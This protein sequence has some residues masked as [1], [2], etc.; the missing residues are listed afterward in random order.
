MIMQLLLLSKLQQLGPP[1]QY[2][3]C[4]YKK[5]PMNAQEVKDLF[6]AEHFYI[7]FRF[8]KADVDVMIHNL[9][10]PKLIQP[11]KT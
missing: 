7:F 6:G 1:K 11:Y 5:Q 8:T 10:L 9:D 3:H 2:Y 4:D